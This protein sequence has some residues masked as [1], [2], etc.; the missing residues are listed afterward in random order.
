MIRAGVLAVGLF[1]V[2]MTG[3]RAGQGAAPPPKPLVPVAAN[4]I[5][6]NPEFF[7]GQHVTVTAAVERIVTATTFTIDQDP[8]GAA[9]AVLVLV[10]TLTAPLA[11]NTYVTVIGEVVRH[12]GGP[13]I[14][15]TSVITTAMVD[16]ARRPPAPMTPDEEAF[17]K[18]MKRINPAFTAIRQAVAAAGGPSAGENAEILKNAFAETDAFWKKRPA[19]DAQKWAAEAR[20]QAELLAEAVAAGKWDVAKAAAGSL[21]QACSSC[22][23]AYRERQDDGSYRIRMESR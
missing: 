3:L 2:F 6:S 7:Y 16:I 10:E 5:A 1:A 17:D 15:A 8:K 19:P 9:P 20:A 12:D 14:R 23:A 22:H 11:L 4:S 13:A 18:I 21:Q